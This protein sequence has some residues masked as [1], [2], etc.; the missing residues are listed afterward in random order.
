MG[1]NRHSNLT[2]PRRPACGSAGA[3][4][5]EPHKAHPTLLDLA[6][7]PLTETLRPLRGERQDRVRRIE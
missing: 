7:P 4:T 3:M 6:L 1:E 5:H 2:Q